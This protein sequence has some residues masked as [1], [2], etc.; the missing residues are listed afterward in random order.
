MIDAYRYTEGISERER[1]DPEHL[2]DGRRGPGT[3]L[4]VEVV[5]FN[6]EELTRLAKSLPIHPLALEDLRTSNQRTKLE[7]YGDHWHVAVHSAMVKDDDLVIKEVDVVFGEDWYLVVRQ[8][9]EGDEPM[10]FDDVE[11]R[12]ERGRIECN[13]DDLG[14]ALWAILDV[15]VDGYFHVTD[16][17][18][19][20]LDDIEEIVFGT[21]ATTRSPR[22]CSRFGAASCSS[23]APPHHYAR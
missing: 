13:N 21:C 4:V 18:D 17:V 8:P 1:I 9:V 22:R 5:D 14:C 16:L 23:V 2:A 12:F 6:D 11:R 10:S 15:I 20:R 7:R 3:L 19:E